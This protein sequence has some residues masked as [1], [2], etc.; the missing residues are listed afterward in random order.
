MDVCLFFDDSCD[1]EERLTLDFSVIPVAFARAI[2]QNFLRRLI[3]CSPG[4]E[5]Q[6]YV[7]RI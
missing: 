6:K 4:I 2:A 7:L 1:T 5:T 3:P